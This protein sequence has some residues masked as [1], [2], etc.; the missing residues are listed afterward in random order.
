MSL[1]IITTLHWF[2]CTFKLKSLNQSKRAML[3]LNDVN[4]SFIF[5][6][7]NQNIKRRRKK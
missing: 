4:L 3:S 2:R 5:W 6:D 1:K 7:E